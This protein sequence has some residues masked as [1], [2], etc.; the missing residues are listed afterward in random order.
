MNEGLKLLFK[1]SIR[2]DSQHDLTEK[3]QD[4]VAVCAAKV[5][6]ARSGLTSALSI[7][8]LRIDCG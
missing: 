4:T 6:T 1:L 2:K 7:E 8:L 5:E 3:D